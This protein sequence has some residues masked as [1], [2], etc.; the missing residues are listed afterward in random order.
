M[1]GERRRNAGAMHQAQLT[2]LHSLADE[3]QAKNVD[4]I[5]HAAAQIH[6]PSTSYK[7][8]ASTTLAKA[9]AGQ[10]EKQG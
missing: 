2:Q 7:N 1:I 8:K 4:N 10:P 5:S 6:D 3:Q 9:K